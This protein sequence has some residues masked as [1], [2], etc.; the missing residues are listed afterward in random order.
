MNNPFYLFKTP[1]THCVSYTLQKTKNSTDFLKC[2]FLCRH[3][4]T[5]KHTHTHTHKQICKHSE[6]HKMKLY[7]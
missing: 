4:H 6:I 5:H 1:I 7:L 2:Q 3:A